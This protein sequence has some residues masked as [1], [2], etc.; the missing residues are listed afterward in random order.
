MTSWDSQK[1]SL[2]TG[3]ELDRPPWRPDI[4]Q[5]TV[6]RRPGKHKHAFTAI[7][8]DIT[9][10]IFRCLLHLIPNQRNEPI[11]G[12]SHVSGQGLEPK[13]GPG[14]NHQSVRLRKNLPQLT[15]NDSL[16]WLVIGCVEIG[17]IRY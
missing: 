10:T 8:Q 12:V 17:K 14:C 9:I 5:P 16:H 15:V 6:I 7:Y 13:L 2:S 4:R 11:E 3:A 1:I